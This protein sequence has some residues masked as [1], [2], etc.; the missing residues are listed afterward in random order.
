MSAA[1]VADELGEVALELEVRLEGAA[2]EAH[3]GG[4]GAVALEP[5]DPGARRRPGGRRAR[6]S[7]SRRGRSPRRG[8]PSRRPAPAASVSVLKRLYVPASRSPSSSAPSSSRAGHR[9]AHRSY[10][11]AWPLPRRGGRRGDERPRAGAVRVEH[12]LAGLAGAEQLEGALEVAERQLLGDQRPQVDDA[13]LEQPAGPVPV[14]KTSPAVDR[15]DVEVLEDQRLGD[16]ELDRPRRD[17]EQDR[18]GRRC[19]RSR[20]ASAIA[21][22]APDI[23]KTTSGCSPSLRSTNHAAVSAAVADVERRRRRPSRSAR[24]RRNGVRS[25]ASDAAGARG[26]RDRRWL[27]RPTGPQ[28]RTA[29]VLPARSACE[30]REDG[31]PER[32]LQRRDLGRQLRAVVLPDDRLRDGDVLR[33]GA[34]A[35]DA[36][37]LRPLAHVRAA[38]AAVDSSCRR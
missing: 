36:E 12:D 31:V 18:R 20:K 22:G 38:G 17:P 19:G 11:T 25:E 29:T 23:S 3:G 34:V 15:R 4:A 32:L 6:G 1:S 35:V 13:V 9:C 16:V 33:E 7:C 8:P 2:D 5:V 24:P 37:D 30:T 14:P 10:G 21:S 27:K 26:A 28:P